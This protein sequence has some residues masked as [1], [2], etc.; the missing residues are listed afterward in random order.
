[1][2]REGS[3]H[4]NHGDGGPLPYT[5]PVTKR[6]YFPALDGLRALAVLSV[7]FFHY[8]AEL[9]PPWLRFGWVGVDVFFVLSGFLIT[10]ILFDSRDA[11]KRWS[12]FYI[13]R[14]L[15]IFPLFYGVLLVLVLTTP[16]AH[17]SWSWSWLSLPGYFFN[18]MPAAIAG[19][20]GQTQGVLRATRNHHTEGTLVF[21]HFWTLCVEEQFYLI[22]PAVVF[23]VRDRRMLLRI[24]AVVVPAV[25]VLRC[26][27]YFT[28]GLN[29]TPMLA[30]AP[31]TR[32]D[33]LL[34][35]GAVA[36]LLRGP[37]AKQVMA[38][39]GRLLVASLLLFCAV[40]VVAVKVFD[41]PSQSDQG[42]SWIVTIGLSCCAF[43]AAGLL[44]VS[45]RSATAWTTFLQW[46]WLRW[47]GQRSYGFY[48]F[49]MIWITPTLRIA[50][51]LTA[52]W[53]FSQAAK[54]PAVILVHAAV[55]FL[56]TLA[57]AAASYRW[58]EQPF[59]RL[60]DRWTRRPPST[61]TRDML[62]QE[63]ALTEAMHGHGTPS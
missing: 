53:P 6:P 7:F 61:A 17:W 58:F 14:T 39:G 29:Q 34:I 51:K 32:F 59:L 20:P 46:S 8:A 33:S 62:R 9:V 40:G 2:P 4:D 50:T 5:L 57:V 28:R 37:A 25:L 41:Q 45:L 44:L 23:W 30:R 19:H 12:D 49:H 55:G 56:I 16:F 43:A 13:R 11:E 26:V 42:T 54:A 24:I 10:G 35:G 47:L 1:M 31:Y 52:R 38:W 63:A 3:C 48:V 21:V 36:L 18:L 22:W 27:L 60:K 15:R